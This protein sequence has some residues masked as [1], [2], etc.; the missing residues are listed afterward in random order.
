MIDNRGLWIAAASAAV[1][2]ITLLVGPHL[3]DQGGDTDRAHVSAEATARPAAGPIALPSASTSPVPSPSIASQ[4]PKPPAPA[5][6]PVATGFAR[7]FTNPGT[8]HADWLARV[9]RWTSDYLTSQYKRTD[10]HRI[11]VATLTGITAVSTGETTVD[12]RAAYDTGLTL[13]CRA[14]LG[15]TGWR[16]ARAMPAKLS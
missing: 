12:F 3:V 11:P 14:E 7:D 4:L 2:G 10:G 6:Q 15:P 1:L 5:W 13:N 9:S 8:G 16:I